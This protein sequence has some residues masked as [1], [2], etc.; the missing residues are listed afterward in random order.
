MTKPLKTL[1]CG[2]K[3]V[4]ASCLESLIK[5]PDFEIVAVLTDDQNINSQTKLI[6]EK[7]QLPVFDFERL[8][9]LLNEEEIEIDI[10]FSVL[11]WK[12]FRNAYLTKIILGIINFH[13]APLP[14]YK[15]LGGYNLAILE[16]RSEWE[17][18]A[19]YVDSNIDTGDIIGF[20]SFT[21]C[22]TTETVETIQSKSQTQ[23]F[24]LFEQILGRVDREKKIISVR[25]NIGGRY[26]NGVEI[27]RLKEIN[28]SDNDDAINRKIRAFW[29]PP[30]S[31]AKV[32]LGTQWFT[33]V[34]TEILE[35][36]TKDS[37]SP[38]FLNSR[39]APK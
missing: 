38:V 18:T 2:R 39:K 24:K 7:Y 30:Y 27:E 3:D 23:I 4:A 21:I 19:H 29:Y 9:I 17:V 32:K 6:C 22:P 15:G 35:R 20:K 14:A 34:N 36:L 13:P 11:Y 37:A 8:E 25:A 31:G 5:H 1:F 10:G 33:L 28:E 12:K 26:Y 16:G